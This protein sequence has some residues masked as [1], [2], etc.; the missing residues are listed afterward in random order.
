MID[1]FEPGRTPVNKAT[2][3]AKVGVEGSNLSARSRFSRLLQWLSSSGG[4]LYEPLPTAVG[5][6]LGVDL[7]WLLAIIGA[8]RRTL[9]A[10]GPKFA[11][12]SC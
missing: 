2:A 4:S 9:A 5:V 11:R 1:E 8:R 10:F 12:K 7:S 6:H 3:L